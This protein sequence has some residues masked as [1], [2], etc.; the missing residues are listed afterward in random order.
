MSYETVFSD[1]FFAVL[2][3][4]VVEK[5]HVARHKLFVLTVPGPQG[6]QPDDPFTGAIEPGGHG[7]HSVAARVE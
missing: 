5:T 2:P 3:S 6:I 7:M 1:A 4:S